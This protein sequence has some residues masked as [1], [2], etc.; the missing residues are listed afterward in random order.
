MNSCKLEKIKE[1]IS[2]SYS[3]QRKAKEKKQREMLRRQRRLAL[4][5]KELNR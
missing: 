1:P 4:I 2:T 5:N 3:K